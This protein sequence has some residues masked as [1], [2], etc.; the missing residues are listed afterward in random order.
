MDKSIF[1][2]KLKVE[3]QTNPLGID[4]PSPRF[5]WMINSEENNVLQSAYHLIVADE[6]GEEVWNT[7][8]TDS[9]QSVWIPYKGPSLKARKCYFWK[10]RIWDNKGQISD[11]SKASWEMGL[12]RK[13]DWQACWIEPEQK[14][15]VE[16]PF[17]TVQEMFSGG[18]KDKSLEEKAKDLRP[19]QL[20]RR[21]FT[22]TGDI[23]KARLYVTSHG[24]YQL[25]L[26]GSRVGNNEFAP[27]FTA[28][29]VRL[30]YQTYDVT[31][32]LTA[33]NNAIGAVIADGWYI[34]R[35]QLTGHSCQFGNKLGLLLQL[36]VE[37]QDGTTE[38]IVSDE[39][40]VSSTGP[41][42]YADL[43]IGEKYDARLEQQDWSCFDFNDQN[44]KNVKQVDYSFDN[45]VAQFGPNV[46]VMEE[47]VPLSV[48]RETDGAQII[49]FGQIIAGRIRIAIEA[50]NGDIITLQHSEVLDK[51]GK[52]FMN[53]IGRNKDQTDIFIAKGNG[54][55]VYEP[56]FV[57]HGFRYVR[58]T[59]LKAPIKKDTVR[60]IVLYSDMETIGHFECSDQRLNRL[61]QNIQWSQ[62]T[63]MLSIP[64][65][66]PQR[67][68]AGWTGDLQV[69]APTAAFN[70]DVYTFLERWL[71]DVRKEQ[72]PDGQIANFVPTGKYYVK[73]CSSMGQLS[74]AGWGDAIII[75][76]WVLYERYGD[77]RVL[78][79]NYEA[80]A[81]WLEYVQEKAE[82]EIP[83]SMTETDPI[84]LERQKY[85]WNTGFHFGDW[86]IPS[87][88]ESAN[89]NTGP[90]DSAILT[91]EL[92]ATCFYANSALLFAKIA[93]LLGDK[94]ISQTYYTLN[95]RIRKAFEEEYIE[96]NGRISAHFQGIYILAL[97]MN[98]VS[99]EKRPLVAAQLAQLIKDND[100]KLDTGFLSVPYL[101]DVLI[102]EGY[103]DIA[104]RIL[105][106]TDCP[107]WLYEVERG[108][109]TIWESWSAIQKDGTVG[110]MSFNHY[111]FGCI[112]DW[113]YREPGGIKHSLPGYK[114]SI[115]EPNVNVGLSSAKAVLRTGYG[116]LSSA[117]ERNNDFI[118]LEVKIPPN[119]TATVIL[120]GENRVEIGS[121]THQFQYK[122]PS[123]L[124]GRA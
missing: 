19:P 59:G 117:W 98:M 57:F 7:G 67:E 58:I 44:W 74:S 81:K 47:I 63:N 33:G 115:I 1:V 27:D 64:T 53:I 15:A 88:V 101:M 21:K 66:C 95:K 84:V 111:A 42:E 102:A 65:D 25:E 26:N 40:F 92:V 99:S 16:E 24:V 60:A 39:Q 77:V 89:E 68:R 32:L 106:Q 114:H 20:L 123:V 108:A 49:D 124:N 76:P 28:Y 113:L 17:I 86:L 11:W 109:T 22:L 12:L 85:L 121:G 31:D 30:Q 105:Y 48:H 45:L 72:F 34:G 80:M 104:Y 9:D 78:E 14:E 4:I 82:T 112:G 55:E 51:D 36:E 122:S 116:I 23:K 96:S 107:S 56:R 100:H 75:V 87:I 91:K 94:E 13:D 93:E 38:R 10:V 43:F 50:R 73:E 46:R 8:K 62:K 2:K 103:E 79:Q 29:N 18:L 41:W 52:F 71:G 69:F 54:S 119:T 61:Q 90:M 118:K 5:S 6:D 35:I 83:V 110:H 70:M 97:Q 3:N 120:H 37:Y